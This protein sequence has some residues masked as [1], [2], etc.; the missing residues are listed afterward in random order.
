MYQIKKCK[1][2]KKNVHIHK[3]HHHYVVRDCCEHF[4]HEKTY[5]QN[6]ISNLTTRE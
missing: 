3:V 5:N 1:V 4:D 6:E 2:C